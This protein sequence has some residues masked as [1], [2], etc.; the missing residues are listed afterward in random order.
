MRTCSLP[1]PSAA[2]PS[3]LWHLERVQLVSSW[4]AVLEVRQNL[5]LRPEVDFAAAT[6]KLTQLIL[7]PFELVS[8]T[9]QTLWRLRALGLPDPQDVPIL[10]G[11]VE[12]KCDYLLTGD[13]K[14]F[15]AYM[16]SSLEGV[17]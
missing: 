11:A 7:P 8:T 15:G 9:E 16:G 10:A 5:R 4:Y 6:E 12:G 13:S 14:C 17:R 3:R 2:E 1:R